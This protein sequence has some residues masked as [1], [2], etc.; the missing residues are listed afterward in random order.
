[1]TVRNTRSSWW[2]CVWT[3]RIRLWTNTETE[4]QSRNCSHD[5]VLQLIVIMNQWKIKVTD[6]SVEIVYRNHFCPTSCRWWCNTPWASRFPGLCLSDLQHKDTRSRSFLWPSV[7]ESRPRT[8]ISTVMFSA[9]LSVCV[10]TLVLHMLSVCFTEMFQS[11]LN[12]L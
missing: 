1:M 2:R 10:Q 6:E 4:T 5:F 3:V 7:P 9:G 8:C 11:F 12:N